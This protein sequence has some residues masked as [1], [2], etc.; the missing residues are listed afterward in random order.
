MHPD[1]QH[2]I[3]LQQLETAAEQGRRRIAEIPAAQEALAARIA[4]RQAAVDDVRDR[5]SACQ[6][7]RRTVEKDLAIIQGRLTKY[8]DQLMEVKTNKEYQ[9]MQKEIAV[10]EREVRSHEDRILERMEEAEELTAAVK[11]TEAELAAE[12]SAVAGERQALDGERAALERELQQGSAARDALVPQIAAPAYRLFDHVFRQRK[13]LAMAEAR[14]GVCTVCHVRLRPQVYNDVRRND[15]LI[16][17]ESCNR[18][19]YS[20]PAAAPSGSEQASSAPR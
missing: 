10:A 9:A 15:S 13:G 14:G 2:L 6:D 5:L 19:L 12:Q 18:I 11:R 16:Q 3:R 8:K 20:S 17:C 1:L 7:A 4:A